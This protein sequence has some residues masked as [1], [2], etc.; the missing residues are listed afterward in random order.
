M[1]ACKPRLPV[2]GFARCISRNRTGTELAHATC[3]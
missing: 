2:I 1:R 3:R